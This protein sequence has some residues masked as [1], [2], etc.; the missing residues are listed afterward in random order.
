MREISSRVGVFGELMR[1]L[2]A[3]KLWWLIPMII[4]L[5]I[6]GFLLIAGASGL[7]PFL[8]SLL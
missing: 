5:I 2:W 7:S 6:V 1:F 8:Y 4:A 3:R